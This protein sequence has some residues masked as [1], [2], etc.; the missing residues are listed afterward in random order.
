[1]KYAA[2]V[3]LQS[4]V[5]QHRYLQ[6]KFLIVLIGFSKL[7]ALSWRSAVFLAFWLLLSFARDALVHLNAIG[8]SVAVVLWFSERP[9]RRPWSATGRGLPQRGFGWARGDQLTNA[10]PAALFGACRCT[11]QKKAP[12]VPGLSRLGHSTI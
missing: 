10:A 1:L 7:A 9:D 8:C 12:G 11:G 5:V 2:P 3:T 6:T 4:A